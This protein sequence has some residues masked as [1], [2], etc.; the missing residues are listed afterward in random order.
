L[1]TYGFQMKENITLDGSP[2]Y[3]ALKNGEVNIVDAF[4]TDGLLKKFGL[5]TL[6]DD[7]GFFP[8]YYAIPVVRADTLEEYPEIAVVLEELAPIL[9]DDVMAELNY[10]VDE[11]QQSP[12]DVAREFLKENG[13]IS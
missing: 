7:K 5:K 12:A 2:R 8:P 1:K 13:L 10:R 4:A 6:E 3:T 9:T 11:L